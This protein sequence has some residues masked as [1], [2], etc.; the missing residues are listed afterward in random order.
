M[1]GKFFLTSRRSW[2]GCS[3]WTLLCSTGDEAPVKLVV[4]VV[5]LETDGAMAFL[6]CLFY[7]HRMFEKTIIPPLKKIKIF[8]SFF[9]L[10]EARELTAWALAQHL[11]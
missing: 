3:L 6:K 4:T 1:E 10:R 8:F 2:L 5:V 7:E 11:F 9:L